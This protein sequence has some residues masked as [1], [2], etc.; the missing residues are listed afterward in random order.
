MIQIC[1]VARLFL[2]FYKNPRAGEVYNIGGGRKNSLSVLET[3]DALGAMGHHLKY[4]YDET[5]RTGDHICY[6]S[7]LTKLSLHFPDWKLE[8]DLPRILDEIIERQ[9]CPEP[10]PPAGTGSSRYRQTSA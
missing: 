2:E 10:H 4:K 3:I 9:G 1:D 8:Y 6:I 5:N 7:D